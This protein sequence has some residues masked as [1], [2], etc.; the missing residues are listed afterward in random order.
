MKFLN[1]LFVKKNSAYSK[2]RDAVAK[3]E[4]AVEPW[5]AATSRLMRLAYPSQEAEQAL[6]DSVFANPTDEAVDAVIDSRTRRPVAA[7]LGAQLSQQAKDRFNAELIAVSDAFY[8][9]IDEARAA[10]EAQAAEL[11]KTDLAQSERLGIS[12]SSE[13]AI[14]DLRRRVEDLT[15]ARGEFAQ[16]PGAARNRAGNVLSQ[17]F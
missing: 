11:E 3:A 10:L 12:I 4:A 1:A 8:A 2:W 6:Y 17:D 13:T 16:S 9:A 5:R 7:T 15:R 14:A